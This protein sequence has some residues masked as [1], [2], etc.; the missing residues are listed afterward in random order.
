MTLIWMALTLGYMGVIYWLS[1]LP[2]DGD[3]TLTSLT[4]IIAWTP[5]AAQNLLHVPLFGLLAWFWYRT[6]GA[7]KLHH[8]PALGIAFMLAAAFGVYDE[9]HQLH[10]PGRYS[11]FTDIALNCAGAVLVL[12]WLHRGK[13]RQLR[14]EIDSH[15]AG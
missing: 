4:G 10:V 1:S 6:L 9:W 11:S 7:L 12:L 13:R 15:P 3:P 5:P 2:G 8:L 14:P